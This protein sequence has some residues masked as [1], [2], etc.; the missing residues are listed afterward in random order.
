[1]P[2]KVTA[3]VRAE[4]LP[5]AVAA[6]FPERPI[7]GTRYRLIAEP[8]EETDEEK[9]A[10]LRADIQEGLDQ[11]AAGFGIDGDEVFAMLEAKYPPPKN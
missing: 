2:T 4:D 3:I 5:K 8:V 10:A 7:P 1:M 9:L 11:L 6:Q